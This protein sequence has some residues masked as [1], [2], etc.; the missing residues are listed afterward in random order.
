MHLCECVLCCECVVLYVFDCM[1]MC[2]IHAPFE[3][4]CVCV[5][6]VCDCLTPLRAAGCTPFAISIL[7]DYIPS[8]MTPPTLTTPPVS[9][10]SLHLGCMPYM[11]IYV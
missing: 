8:V 5:C 3:R 9:P 1:C 11:G 2:G 6:G 7:S 10:I 4:V